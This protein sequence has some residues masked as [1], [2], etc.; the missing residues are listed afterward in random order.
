MSIDHVGWPSDH[1]D[2]F[3]FTRELRSGLT[4]LGGRPVLHPAWREAA[5]PRARMAATNSRRAWPALRVSA[6]SS[7]EGRLAA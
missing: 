2:A 3:S 5:E 4:G 7:H 1:E 6:P